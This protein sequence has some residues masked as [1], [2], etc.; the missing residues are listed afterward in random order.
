MSPVCMAGLW[1]GT[2]QGCS[3]LKM[4]RKLRDRLA[5]HLSERFDQI[6][7]EDW[8]WLGGA[9]QEEGILSG[10]CPGQLAYHAR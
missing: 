7:D 9:V 6:F 8:G 2:C 4:M 3:P 5:A 10:N 1:R